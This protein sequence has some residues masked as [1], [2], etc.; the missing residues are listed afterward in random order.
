LER[1]TPQL[2]HQITEIG[3]RSKARLAHLIALVLEAI[4]GAATSLSKWKT[5]ATKNSWLA[6]DR[7]AAGQ[8]AGHVVLL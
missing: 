4:L 7:L 1:Y 3:A 5:A 2:E 8:L 6:L